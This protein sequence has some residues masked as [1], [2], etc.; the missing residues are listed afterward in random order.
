[1]IGTELTLTN[2]Q[3]SLFAPIALTATV[4]VTSFLIMSGWWAPFRNFVLPQDVATLTMLQHWRVMG[5][6]FLLLY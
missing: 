6:S 1:L 4:P 2:D 3:A 5:V